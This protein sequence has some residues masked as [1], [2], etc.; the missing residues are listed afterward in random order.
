V[1]SA[2]GMLA[3]TQIGPSSS[4]AAVLIA[5]TVVFVG[6]S[7]VGPLVSQLVVPAAP[8]AKAGSA[9]S[10]NATSGELGVALGIAVLGSIGAAVYRGGVTV[11]AEVA[12][13]PA[14]QVASETIGGAFSVAQSL[15]PAVASALTDSARAAFTSGLN[16]TAAVCAVAFVA[17]AALA[18]SAL[19]HVQPLK[20]HAPAETPTAPTAEA[21]TTEADREPVLS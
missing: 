1:I 3:L 7:P 4:L 9:S 19:R 17:L 20:A 8:P 6:A 2:I 11:P 21:P 16:A 5:I 18:V 10:L 14:A 15:P 12:G 13:T